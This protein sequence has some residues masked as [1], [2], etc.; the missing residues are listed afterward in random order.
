MTRASRVPSAWAAGVLALALASG[1]AAASPPGDAMPA[2]VASVLTDAADAWSAGSLDR[3]MTS[4]ER[5]PGTVYVSGGRVVRGW[6]AIRAMYA[7]RFGGGATLGRL[8]LV[9]RE[10]RPLGRDDAFCLASYR[11]IRP[12]APDD[13]GVTTLI[14]HRT[15][16]GWRI[17]V[18]HSS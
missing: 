4:Y 18:D 14:L 11:L 16:S 2:A 1:P 10:V 3:F 9:V 15:R 13:A 8:S 17:S 12:A 7:S 6:A 5:S